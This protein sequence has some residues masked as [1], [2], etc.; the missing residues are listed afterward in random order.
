MDSLG[1]EVKSA[2]AA[3]MD[4]VMQRM[5]HSGETIVTFRGFRG[6]SLTRP[7]RDARRFPSTRWCPVPG[8]GYAHDVAGFVHRSRIISLSRRVAP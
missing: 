7:F 2:R 3:A 8:G 1:G 5:Q 6:R 4:K